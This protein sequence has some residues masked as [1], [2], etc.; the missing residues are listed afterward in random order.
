MDTELKERIIAECREMMS[1][2]RYGEQKTEQFCDTVSDILQDFT[3]TYDHEDREISYSLKKHL[4][5]VELRLDISGNKLDPLTDGKD[6]EELR[7]K[8]AVNSVLFNPETSVEFAYTPGCNHI[9]VKSASKA[10]NSTL[11]NDSMVKAM[12]LG[13]AAG[14]ICKVLPDGVS[15]IRC[16]LPHARTAR[17]GS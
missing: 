3:D 11:L 12:L 5:F 8:S 7:L 17:C 9:I 16:D 15:G 2:A 10:A 1:K 4:D 14:I 6:A 13:I